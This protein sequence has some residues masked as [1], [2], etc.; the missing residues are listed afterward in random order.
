VVRRR[1]NM[2]ASDGARAS[3]DIKA[4]SSEAGAGSPQENA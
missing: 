2:S 1:N 4:F 3:P